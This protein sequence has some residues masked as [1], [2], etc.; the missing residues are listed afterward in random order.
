[1]T[2]VTHLA[3]P[4][5][6]GVPRLGAPPVPAPLRL[7]AAAARGEDEEERGGEEEE[8]VTPDRS[9]ASPVPGRT[10]LR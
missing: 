2:S 5:C 7:W 1:M 3:A 4:V 9:G 8:G 10:A 6:A